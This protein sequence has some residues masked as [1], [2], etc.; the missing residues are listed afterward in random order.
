MFPY[1]QNATYEDFKRAPSG[2]TAELI[3]GNLYLRHL[4]P[5]KYDATL[6]DLFSAPAEKVAEMLY[7]D[8]YLSTR[9]GPESLLM[10]AKL[11]ASIGSLYQ[12]REDPWV[13]MSEPYLHH[14]GH[15]LVPDLCAWP[16]SSLCLTPR[17][18][19]FAVPQTPHWVCELPYQR[20]YPGTDVLDRQFKLPIYARM[21]IPHIWVLDADWHELDIYSA[22]DGHLELVKS[23]KT[24]RP[25]RAEPF[26]D[27]VLDLA[28]LWDA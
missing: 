14:G 17:A 27:A 16:R 26:P 21:K 8:L 6:S 23:Y 24:G 15:Y 2:W 12:R 11:F 19:D 10:R 28:D 3:D 22:A 18:H 4:E 7:G 25:V 20:P 9:P 1:K 5:H 13:F